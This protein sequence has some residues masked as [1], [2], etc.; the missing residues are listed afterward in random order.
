VT[1]LDA[2]TPSALGL[3]VALGC[4]LLIGLERERRKGEGDDRAAAGLRSFGVAAL[5]GA[6]A[7]GLGGNEL[8]VAGALL[9]AA[10][11]T[12]SHFKSRS[13]DPG[14]TTELALFA[15]YLVGVQAVQSPA[16]GAACGVG[17]AV[18]LAARQ[19]MH[20]FA[21]RV[22]T[23]QE[24]HDA[25]M[26]AAMALVLLP[27]VPRGPQAWLGGIA[28]QPLTWL[29]LLILLLQALGH[30][31]QRAW[32]ERRGMA[33]SGFLSG[34]VSSTATIASLGRRVPSATPGKD[35]VI[36]AGSAVLST[37]ATWVQVL[38]MSAALSLDAAHAL[39]PPAAAGFV[40]ALIGGL[41]LLANAGQ[42]NAARSTGRARSSRS[43]LRM[44]EALLVALVLCIVTL[45]V[46][47]A[48]QR[49]GAT[50]VMASVALAGLADAHSPVASLASLFAAGRLDAHGLVSAVWV[51]VAANSAMR[52]VVASVSGGRRF[53]TH[54]GAALL[55]ELA[56]AAGAAWLAW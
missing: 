5:A 9:V 45:L 37:A 26:L 46:S 41:A 25:L 17:L 52:T 31:A 7:R 19:S 42:R 3:A 32:G 30:V 12:V 29:V 20:R 38:L 18:L 2:L 53:G 22:L 6:L 24:L 16:L 1:G 44:R 15:T 13:S 40:V 50:G 4:G 54:I 23:E 33:V 14:V 10:L 49:F 27:L 35:V 8:V 11:A 34:F 39:L 55:V 48:Q 51:T 43:A 28:L 36:L 56:A 21:T 47:A